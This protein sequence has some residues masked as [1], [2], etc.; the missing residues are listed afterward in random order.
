M[1]KNIKIKEVTYERL[2]ALGTLTDTYD[3]VLNELIK[4]YKEV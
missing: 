1:A 3:S 4:E 2:S